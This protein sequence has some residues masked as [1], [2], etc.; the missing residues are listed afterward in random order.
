MSNDN[1]SRPVR[2]DVARVAGVAESTVSRALND[3]PL[4]SGAVKEKVR[5]A[6]LSLGYVPSRQ[7]AMF[8]RNRSGSIGLVVPRYSAFPPFSRAYFP[9]V[10]DGVVVAAEKRG[11]FVTIILDR[12]D[13]SG[14]ELAQLVTGKS[15]D[16]LLFTV[17][18]AEYSRYHVLEKLGLP[19]VLI[20]NYHEA[21]SSVDAT[22]EP[23]MRKAMEHACSL[24]HRTIGYIT[25]DLRY[26]NGQD[27]LRVFRKLVSE[28]GVTARISEGDFSRTSGYRCA[29]EILSGGTAAAGAPTLIMAASDRAALGV[30][31]WCKDRGIA[32]PEELSLIGYDD[33]HPA[34]DADP[35]LSTVRNPISEGGARATDLLLDIVEGTCTTP[36]V[37]WLDTDYVSRESTGPP[38]ALVPARE[39]TR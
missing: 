7:A 4:I 5:R 38:S 20:S 15:V 29:G 13:A 39:T 33:L 30:L 21:M 2:A 14:E 22:P 27:R 37:L 10:L 23:G 16:G 36:T 9:A 26:T 28:Y 18:P 3:S 25:G 12:A 31:A 8:A 34:Q 24:G 6:A 35:P 19:F 32:V 1:D 11:C 17:S